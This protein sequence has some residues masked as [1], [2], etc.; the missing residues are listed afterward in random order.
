MKGELSFKIRETYKKSTKKA[1]ITLM[2]Y[3]GSQVK[4]E[5]KF[6]IRPRS[7]VVLAQERF[8][9]LLVLTP[10][11]KLLR[12]AFPDLDIT[13][14][15]V[16]EIIKIL[17]HDNNLTFVTNIKRASEAVKKKIFS[18]NYDLLYNTKD[19][20]SFTF[21]KLTGKLHADHKVGILHPW[22]RGFFHHMLPLADTMPTVEKNCAL[23]PY[24]GISLEDKDMQPYL[25]PGPVNDNVKK[26]VSQLRDNRVIGINLSASNRSK[27]WGIERWK[28]FLGQINE[29]VVVLATEEH[30]ADKKE[31]EKSFAHILA[32]PST[33]TIFDVGWIIKHLGLLVTPDTALVHVASCFNTP[34]VAL[35]RLQRDLEKFKPLSEN[36]RIHVTATGVIDDI[37]PRDVLVS[38][39]SLWREVN[40]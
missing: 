7:V 40:N 6:N 30:E 11:F 12:Q 19:H 18:C 28:F 39:H 5:S 22:H 17:D 25:P 27:E 35:Y 1:A 26:F 8:G 14:L 10:L 21:L 36:K 38:F 34:I 20:P 2:K 13:V 3:L 9:D 4:P 31:L 32:S 33:P 16:T 23:L 24:L 29:K 37:S 15:G